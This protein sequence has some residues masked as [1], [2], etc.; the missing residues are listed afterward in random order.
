[1]TG[2]YHF[3]EAI[4]TELNRFTKPLGLGY[5]SLN[6]YH[7]YLGM[8]LQWMPC[9][10][11]GRE[12]TQ[13]TC[14]KVR[15]VDVLSFIASIKATTSREIQ[16]RTLQILRQYF[17][18][19]KHPHNPA[20]GIKIKGAI[21]RIPHNLLDKETLEYL[22]K[23]YPLLTLNNYRDKVITGLV[24]YQAL[25][26]G[27]LHKIRLDDVKLSE[28]KVHI[29]AHSN[30]NRRVLALEG[31]QIMELHEYIE[32]IRP[33]FT[34]SSQQLF[35]SSIGNKPIMNTLR[36][37]M[38]TLRKLHPQVKNLTQ[39]RSS[40]IAEWLKDKDVRIV[41]YMAG[42]KRVSSTERYQSIN[43]KDLQ[44]QLNKFHP[45]NYEAF[46]TAETLV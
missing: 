28:G 6:R 31:F 30:M 10:P 20:M 32:Q 26:S 23:N 33:Q 13:L 39:L 22:Y 14:D 2:K 41:Q 5:V 38:A 40:V 45:L 11:A 12:Q 37:L 43:L 29:R 42:H 24:V 8:F 3:S 35:I 17:D 36:K 16:N 46:L 1:M 34:G 27:D 15:T 19:K 18:D 25:T 9:L 4:N 7:N 44:E 21:K